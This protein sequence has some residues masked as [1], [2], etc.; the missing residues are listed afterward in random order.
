M[1]FTITN[2]RTQPEVLRSDTSTK[3]VQRTI[4]NMLNE[5]R[6][7]D[8]AAAGT[9]AHA[10]GRARGRAPMRAPPRPVAFRWQHTEHTVPLSI[11]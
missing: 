4:V 10:T 5:K 8:T 9:V 3:H 7:D 1:L 2:S 6:D 11:K